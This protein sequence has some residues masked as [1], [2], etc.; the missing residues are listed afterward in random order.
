MLI[1]GGL[2]EALIVAASLINKPRK[3]GIEG[4]AEGFQE[5]AGL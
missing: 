3:R 4:L 2:I 1:V 5:G